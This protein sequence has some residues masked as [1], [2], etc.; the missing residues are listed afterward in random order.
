MKQ[1]FWSLSIFFWLLL[2]L[3]FVPRKKNCFSRL[4]AFFFV[5]LHIFVF[6]VV[7]SFGFCFV[8]LLIKCDLLL[9]FSCIFT[10]VAGTHREC[11]SRVERD[12]IT[13]HQA[14]SNSNSTTTTHHQPPIYLARFKELSVLYLHDCFGTG[15]RVF[16]I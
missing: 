6:P 5:F 15:E 14:N 9:N 3:M 4:L 7:C 11:S 2:F 8:W 10:L 16:I 13:N 1:L 12:K